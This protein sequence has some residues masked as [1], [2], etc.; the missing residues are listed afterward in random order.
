MADPFLSISDFE[1]EYPGAL[2]AGQKATATRVLQVASDRVRELKPD[3]D[4]NAA[5]QVV[6]EIARDAV[7]YGHLGPLSSFDNET[8]RRREAGTF[9]E[10]AKAVDDL[11][12]DR[13]KRMLG[14][15]LRVAPR[16]K[17]AKCDY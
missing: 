11:L 12:T 8:S 16:G 13:H 17:F 9:D 3:A 5:K 1:A 15:A 14:I 4:E 6:F 2:S 7:M 10:V